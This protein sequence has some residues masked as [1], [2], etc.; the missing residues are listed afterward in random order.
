M[1]D[2]DEMVVSTTRDD[3]KDADIDIQI[4]NL[5]VGIDD[6]LIDTNDDTDYGLNIDII[7]GNKKHLKE[8][9][10]ARFRAG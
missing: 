1:C 3:T 8:K 4:D 10:K 5:I 7:E 2:R 9:P 6:M